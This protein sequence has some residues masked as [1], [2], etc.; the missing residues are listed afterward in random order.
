LFFTPFSA[1]AR[2]GKRSSGS[3]S[4]SSSEDKEEKRERKHAATPVGQ[5][6]DRDSSSNDDDDDD[7]D[8][9]QPPRR[10]HRETYVYVA[11]PP[12]VH[13]YRPTTVEQVERTERHSP[14]MVRMGLLANSMGGGRVVGL[15]LLL[16]GR[17]LGLSTRLTSIELP[18]DDG[19]PGTDDIGLGDMH[20]TWSPWSSPQGRFRLEA[21]LAVAAAPDVTFV[22]PSLGASFERC[23]MGPLDVEGKLHI[24]PVPHRA[25]DLQGGLALH[26]GVLSLRG[27][28][29]M[30]VLDDA[31]LVD[32][33]V[34]RDVMAGP[35]AGI[36]LNF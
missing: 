1:E 30:M 32:G 19:T 5:K 36:G 35:Y 14:L 21:G 4:S 2:F 18:T 10:P 34:H 12:P 3:S 17:E 6:P 26:L 27:G 16:E 7:D 28:W 22:G 29:R 11:P 33:E 25:A 13:S 20:L 15:N 9:Y 8:S 31:G 24:V 23:L